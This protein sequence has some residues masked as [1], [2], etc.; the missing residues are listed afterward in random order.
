MVEICY[1]TRETGCEDVE[2]GPSNSERLLLLFKR[3]GR[4]NER[5]KG[6]QIPRPNP[7]PRLWPLYNPVFNSQRQHKL[8]L[9]QSR[10]SEAV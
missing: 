4:R 5:K 10:F 8:D 1:R 9:V 3:C 6:S 7:L 2:G